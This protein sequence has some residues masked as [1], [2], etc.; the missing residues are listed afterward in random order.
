MKHQVGIV[1]QALAIALAI[2]LASG[3]AISS[4][5]ALR[6]SEAALAQCE[7]THGEGATECALER[8]AMLRDQERFEEE[9]RRAWGCEA[10]GPDGDCPTPR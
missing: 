9:G 4:W 6:E 3:C 8:E 1:W 5:Q 7:A 10:G 2:A